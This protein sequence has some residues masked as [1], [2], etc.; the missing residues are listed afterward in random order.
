[1][2]RKTSLT[3][4]TGLTAAIIGAAAL[5][6]PAAAGGSISINVKPKNEKQAKNMQAGLALYGI[7]NAVKGGASIKQLGQNNMAGIGQ[8]GGGNFG[9]IH[10]QGDN[11]AGTLQQNGNNNAYGIFQFGKNTDSN[12]VQNGNGDV[13]ATFQFGW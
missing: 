11:H 13:G 12:V 1:M 10:Q 4:V 2:T 6:T 3:L 8:N 7:V 9:V 5:T